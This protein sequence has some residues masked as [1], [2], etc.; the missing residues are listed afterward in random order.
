MHIAVAI[1]I[2][3]IVA[4]LIGAVPFALIVGKYG[5][6]TDLREHGSGN[7]GATNVWRVLGWKAGL[8]VFFLDVAKGAAAAGVATVVNLS[9]LSA[10]AKDWVLIVAAIAAVVGHSYSPYIHLRGGKGVA[11]A[12]GALLV[13]TPLAWPILFATFLLIVFTTRIVSLASIIIAIEFPILAWL[14]YGDRPA[15]VTMSVIAASFVLWRH[16]S[17]I[18]RIFKGEEAKMSLAGRTAEDGEGAP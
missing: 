7:L 6:K 4:F 15:I 14:L 8:I 11:P 9:G 13:I 18:R 10:D 17:N 5:Y 2:S 1:S 16:Q 3:L 12:A